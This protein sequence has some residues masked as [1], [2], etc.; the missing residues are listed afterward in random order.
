MKGIGHSGKNWV[1]KNQ[2]LISSAQVRPSPSLEYGE[3]TGTRLLPDDRAVRKPDGLRLE[4]RNRQ[5]VGTGTVEYFDGTDV[6]I[7]FYEMMSG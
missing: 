2:Q 1:G 4:S 7:L 6:T 3:K 5:S